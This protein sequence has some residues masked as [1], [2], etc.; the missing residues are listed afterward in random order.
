MQNNSLT[1]VINLRTWLKDSDGLFNY[2][3]YE[4]TEEKVLIDDEV[5]IMREEEVCYPK[6]VGRKGSGMNCLE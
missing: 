3:T 1:L 2:Y 4:Y 6:S 5:L